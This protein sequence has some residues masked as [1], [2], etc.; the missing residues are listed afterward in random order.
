[1]MNKKLISKTLNTHIYNIDIE[2]F[3]DEELYHIISF[4]ERIY[5]NS[6]EIE[7]KKIDNLNF[8]SLV[9]LTEDIINKK[10]ETEHDDQK[11]T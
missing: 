8:E 10:K 3:N 6:N 4:M 11:N 1:M 7:N 2:E 5:K 9:T